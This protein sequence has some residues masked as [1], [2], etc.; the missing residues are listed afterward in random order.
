MAYC[1][2]PRLVP[3]KVYDRLVTGIHAI[4]VLDGDNSARGYG[5]SIFLIQS[6]LWYWPRCRSPYPLGSLL[7]PSGLVVSG[8]SVHESLG[9]RAENHRSEFSTASKSGF[10]D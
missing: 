7:P 1:W 9:S 6:C 3:V 10:V 8:F 4:M 2:G 5:F